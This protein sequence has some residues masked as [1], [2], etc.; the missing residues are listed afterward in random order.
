[1]QN[2]EKYPSESKKDLEL[3]LKIDKLLPLKTIDT[4]DRLEVRSKCIPIS[5]VS[6]LLGIIC[7]LTL[8]ITYYESKNIYLI[9]LMALFCLIIGVVLIKLIIK[10]NLHKVGKNP[11]ISLDKIDKRLLLDYE[12]VNI[13]LS[14]IVEFYVLCAGFKSEG[15]YK[16]GKVAELSVIVSINGNIRRY[17]V[18][19]NNIFT[20]RRV[21]KKI[22]EY[23]GKAL[24]ENK[25]KFAETF[26][27]N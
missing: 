8:I 27:G 4:S 9:G 20:I 17:H 25:I 19:T 5:L 1:M 11:I 26:D 22:S 2:L 7:L 14:D 21:A 13:N 16:G 18:L 12:G 6:F 3:F 23:T 24:D 15:Y 10:Y